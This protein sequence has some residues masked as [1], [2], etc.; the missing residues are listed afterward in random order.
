[1]T[2]PAL[3]RPSWPG[4]ARPALGAGRRAAGPGRVGR[5]LGGGAAPAAAHA[6]GGRA[7]GR[8]G[9]GRAGR[10]APRGGARVSFIFV[11]LYCLL[12]GHSPS[13][14]HG[15]TTPRRCLSLTAAARSLPH[16]PLTAHGPHRRGHRTGDLLFMCAIVYLYR[17]TELISIEG[18]QSQ[19]PTTNSDLFIAIR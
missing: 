17:A 7:G 1:M 2:R 18:V 9:A 12:T 13:L 3:L 19:Q 15:E 11:S 14:A 4:P 16:A 8:P 10:A 6:G 5:V